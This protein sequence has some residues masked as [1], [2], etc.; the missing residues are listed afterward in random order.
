MGHGKTHIRQTPKKTST[1]KK[2]DFVQRSTP[3]GSG[4]TI[5][6]KSSSGGGVTGIKPGTVWK[7]STVLRGKKR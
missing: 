3:S 2:K 4:K 7:P 1:F 5:T 6:K